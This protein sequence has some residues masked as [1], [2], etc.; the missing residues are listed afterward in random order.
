MGRWVDKSVRQAREKIIT[1]MLEQGKTVT[2]IAKYI[3]IKPGS[4]ILVKKKVS[5][6]G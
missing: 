5:N 2:E 3:G 1:D 6:K 4:V